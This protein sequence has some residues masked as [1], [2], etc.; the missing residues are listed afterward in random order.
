[1]SRKL[2]N[3]ALLLSEEESLEVLLA[4][5]KDGRAKART[6]KGKELLM[7]IGNTGAGKSTF[8]NYLF[9]CELEVVNEG[10][11][12]IVRVRAGS[13]VK[14]V[15]EIGHTNQSKTFIPAQAYDEDT[16]LTCL[17]C[18]GFLD[19]RGAEINIANVRDQYSE[20]CQRQERS[21]QRQRR[22]R[23]VPHQLQLAQG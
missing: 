16:M 12:R 1:M 20:C 10:N 23:A 17:D 3:A 21:L 13:A 2:D 15:M 18:P 6:S 22:A 11:K 19:S 8:I 5:I 4:C 9:G 7:V 14:E